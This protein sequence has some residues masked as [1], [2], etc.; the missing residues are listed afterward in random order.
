MPFKLTEQEQTALAALGAKALKDPSALQALADMFGKPIQAEIDDTIFTPRLLT[1]E[2][3]QPGPLPTY[4][5]SGTP[6]AHWT[7]KDGDAIV[8]DIGKDD[9]L[10]P[11]PRIIQSTVSVK[12]SDLTRGNVNAITDKQMLASRVL[13]NKIDKA[14]IDLISASVPAANVVQCSGGRL[15]AAA[16]D[17]ACAKLGDMEDENLDAAN[18]VM[19]QGRMSDVKSFLGDLAKEEMRLKG[20]IAVYN[21]ASV[22]RTSKI[23]NAEV[24]ILPATEIGKYLVTQ[25]LVV[26]AET[27]VRKFEVLFTVWMEIAQLMTRP[28]YAAKVVI[29]A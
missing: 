11:R 4:P 9:E 1:E 16:L 27:N 13:R 19:R 24:L 18:I 26:E 15:T 7:D 21:G 14:S 5:K 6:K 25:D 23:S 3:P 8:T 22:L 29:T 17:A 2:H 20:F 28:E 10:I 12:R